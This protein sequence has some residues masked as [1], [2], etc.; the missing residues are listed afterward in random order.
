MDFTLEVT[1]HLVCHGMTIL[2]PWLLLLIVNS[3]WSPFVLVLFILEV[4][5]LGLSSAFPS[6]VWIVCMPCV[7]I[8][9]LQL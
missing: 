1:S 6:Y 3:S 7:G 4:A 8:R 5:F 2:V 9:I